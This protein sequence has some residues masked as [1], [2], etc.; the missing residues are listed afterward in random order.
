MLYTDGKPEVNWKPGCVYVT[1][2]TADYTGT[3]TQS[4]SL[5]SGAG[6]GGGGMWVHYRLPGLAIYDAWKNE[7]LYTISS[8]GGIRLMSAG[9]DGV[10]QYNPGPNHV[11]D[12]SDPEMAPTGD[13]INGSKDNVVQRVEEQQ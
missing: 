10:F 12:S 1:G 4:F 9:A 7:I 5:A 3:N 13:D 11:L 8:Q 6:G 2:G